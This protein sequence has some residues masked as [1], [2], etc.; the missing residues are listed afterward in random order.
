MRLHKAIKWKDSCNMDKETF[1]SYLERGRVVL[2]AKAKD[3]Q[4]LKDKADNSFLPYPIF[5]LI[6]L[7]VASGLPPFTSLIILLQVSVLFIPE[8][9]WLIMNVQGKELVLNYP[10]FIQYFVLNSAFPNAMF[11][12]W[13]IA[14]FVFIANTVL[15]FTH[16]Q[17]REFPKF[18]VR[19]S[20]KLSTSGK[21]N[22][23][24]FAM[25]LLMF[26][27]LYIWV[28]FGSIGPPSFLRGFVPLN[29]RLAMLVFHG[30]QISL[31]IPTVLALFSAEL[32]ATFFKK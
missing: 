16:I 18:L 22:D 23:L 9:A 30:I 4:E 10:E 28:V 5:W 1:R 7:G 8:A 12:F 17:F 26:I 13:F 32:R 24:V 19:R 27:L 2:S 14:P 20:A 29:N 6:N 15:C 31:V 21:T 11:A 25:Q 3:E